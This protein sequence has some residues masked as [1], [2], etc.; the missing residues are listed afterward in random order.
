MW[1]LAWGH[2]GAPAAALIPALSA[3]TG[4][5]RAVA[6]AMS[7]ERQTLAS[8]TISTVVPGCRGS[9]IGSDSGSG[10]AKE[11]MPSHSVVVVAEAGAVS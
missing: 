10:T 9:G 5:E 3:R 2:S 6:K 4:Q 1:A 11:F 8:H 7:G